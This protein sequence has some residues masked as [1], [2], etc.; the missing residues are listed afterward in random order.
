MLR[1]LS[2]Q[3]PQRETKAL[4]ALHG[5]SAVLLGLL[6]YAVVITGAVAVFAE[7]IRH[8]SVGNV[9]SQS[10][11]IQP[12]D[13][14]V[15]QHAGNVDPAHLEEVTL[16][17]SSS[18][19]L[20]IFY[21]SHIDQPDGTIE[22]YG[23]AVELVVATGEV[24][25]HRVT[26][27]TE[28]REQEN[29]GALA[30]FIV[31][32][33]TE[34]HLPR[35][36]GLMLTGILGLVL[37]VSAI[38]GFLIHGHLLKEAFTLRRD[39]NPLLTRRDVHSLAG[40]WGLP[41]AF[42]LAFTGS[43]F[44]FAGAFGIPAMAMVAFGGDQETM[45]RTLIDQPTIESKTPGPAANLDAVI[46]DATRRAGVAPVF[47]SV[48]G[49][50]VDA[51]RITV[52]APASDNRLTGRQFSYDGNSGEFQREKPAL[53]KV[54]SAGAT[55]VSL[56]APLHFGNF[57]GILSKLVWGALAF[58][59][60]YVVIT[61]F[62]LWLK[63]REH[64]PGWVWLRRGLLA[65]GHG[66]PIAML[67]CA[68]AY[69]LAPILGGNAFSA[70]PASFVAAALLVL[71]WSA[72]TRDLDALNSKLLVVTIIL[73]GLLPAT[74]LMTGGIGWL[75]ALWQGNLA[76]PMLDAVFLLCAVFLAIQRRGVSATANNDPEPLTLA[77]TGTGQQP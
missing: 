7:E 3:L 17:T 24:L 52:F 59:L 55:A 34:L 64:E 71:G 23:D 72:L 16:S 62:T 35:P 9:A 28:L 58:A 10:P 70:V 20:N 25:S 11:F 31:S 57:A 29:A 13:R 48:S 33:H 6:L 51:S 76:V 75:D 69:F 12:L 67:S 40:T 60:C 73:C 49:W 22:E 37:L 14:W 47:A 54:P 63:R 39:R 77:T 21:H 26:T 32:I 56:M 19:H 15:R 50:G 66:I 61:G 30:R 74:R 27:A 36:W 5:W 53:G 42:V 1:A 41:F 4:V 38:S 68:L 43:F 45:I 65:F 44:S 46:A 18:G 2:V 8:W